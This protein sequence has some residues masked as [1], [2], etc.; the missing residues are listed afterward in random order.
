MVQLFSIQLVIR[1][2]FKFPPHPTYASALPGDIKTYEISVKMNKKRQKPTVTS[3]IETWG[4]ITRFFYSF[5]YK[6]F[7]H[8]WPLNGHSNSKLTYNVCCCITWGNRTSAVWD[9]KRKINISKFNHY[10][11][12]TALVTVHLTVFAM[13]CSSKFMG[14]CLEISMNSKSDWLKSEAEHYQHCYQR[15]E[16]A[17]PCLCLHKWPIFRIVTV[18]SCTTKQFEKLST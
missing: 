1:R 15:M 9:K 4:R 12:V 16:N 11:Y 2:L 5:W 10:R 8:N 13:L 18:S 14:R 7:W 6:H 17:S 3:L